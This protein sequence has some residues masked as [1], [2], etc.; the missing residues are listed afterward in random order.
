MTSFKVSDSFHS[1]PCVVACPP[2][3]LALWVLA[4]SWIARHQTAGRVPAGIPEHLIPGGD[5]HARA[6]VRTKLWKPRR[7]AWEMVESLPAI[8]HGKPLQLWTL[9]RDD[10]RKKIP[11]CIRSA[12]FE[13]DEFRCVECAATD[14]LT[15]DHIHP[16]SLGGKDTVENLRLL[17]RSCNSRKGARI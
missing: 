6:L 2:S 13:R 10:Y 4:G 1:H 7:G 9:E 8:P 15:L 17:C 16:W 11:E 12:V 3:A 5:D 14:D